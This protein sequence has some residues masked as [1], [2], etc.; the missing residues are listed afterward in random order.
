MCYNLKLVV[1]GDE[2]DKNCTP[3]S[4]LT[5]QSFKIC[6]QS[7]VMLSPT[8]QT[9]SSYPTII[10][11]CILIPAHSICL[12]LLSIRMGHVTVSQ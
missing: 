12:S 5:I 8:L 11:V 6:I 3:K 10:S 2:N 4:G 1:D 9:N 7:C